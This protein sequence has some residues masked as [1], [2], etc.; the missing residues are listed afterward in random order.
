MLAFKTI[1]QGFRAGT[2]PSE[3]SCA[4]LP[5]DELAT[6]AQNGG[7]TYNDG[8]GNGDNNWVTVPVF[9]TIIVLIVVAIGVVFFAFYKRSQYRMRRQVREILREY[10]PLDDAPSMSESQRREAQI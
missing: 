6:C 8:N 1:C 3:C 2:E 5:S 10:V 4:D 9:V 7:Q